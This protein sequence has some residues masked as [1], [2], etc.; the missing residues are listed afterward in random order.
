MRWLRLPRVIGVVACVYLAAVTVFFWYQTSERFRFVN[1]AQRVT[2]EVIALQSRPLAGATRLPEADSRSVPLAPTVRYVVDGKRYEYT[3]DHGVIGN[4][5]K[6]GDKLVVR[7][8]PAAPS[9]A[10]LQGEG[11]LLLPLI[12]AGFATTT[13][14]VATL[15]FLTR[16]AGPPAHPGPR[17]R[18][19]VAVGNGTA[20]R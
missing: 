3:P 19:R 12:T 13:L 5:I 10:R 9:R 17:P 14:G 7:Y 2:G 6:V 11:R 20:T 4:R 1:N 15:L 18:S 16:R 8:D